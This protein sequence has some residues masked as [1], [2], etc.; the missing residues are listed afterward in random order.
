MRFSEPVL[1]RSR[2]DTNIDNPYERK[3]FEKEKT[4]RNSSV[5]LRASRRNFSRKQLTEKF[6]AI[7]NDRKIEKRKE[8]VVCKFSKKNQT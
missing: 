5:K 3:T 8:T 2:N 4:N 7:R 1:E 6:Q